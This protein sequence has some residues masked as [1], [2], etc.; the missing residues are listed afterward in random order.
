MR[1][2]KGSY[3]GYFQRRGGIEDAE[4]RLNCFPSNRLTNK[5]ILDIGCSSGEFT[6]LIAKT[7]KPQ[8]VLGVDIDQKLIDTANNHLQTEKSNYL[9]IDNTYNASAKKKLV[10]RIVQKPSATNKN[11][12]IIHDRKD[13]PHNVNFICS[14]ILDNSIKS[15]SYDTIFCLSVVKWIHLV[16]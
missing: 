5:I 13:Y 10:P 9:L 11:V 15:C 16:L 3:T 4:R 12:S 8:S 6:M 2:A 7:F 14:T 1:T